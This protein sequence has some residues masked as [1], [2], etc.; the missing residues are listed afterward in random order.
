MFTWGEYLLSTDGKRKKVSSVQE[1]DDESK[2]LARGSAVSDSVDAAPNKYGT[3]TE[4]RDDDNKGDVSPL[5]REPALEQTEIRRVVSRMA[6][7]TQALLGEEALA[8]VRL[9]GSSF[10]SDNEDLFGEGY[11]DQMRQHVSAAAKGSDTISDDNSDDFTPISLN[12]FS[13]ALAL[14]R[15]IFSSPPLIAAFLGLVVG[16]IPALRDL[17]VGPE[18]PLRSLTGALALCGKM[19]VPAS[20]IML[21]G[22]GAI[23]IEK[24]DSNERSQAFVFSNGARAT[25]LFARAT[26]LGF[27]G[28]LWY[29]ICVHFG[30]HGEHGLVPFLLLLEATVPSAQNV[31][32]LML[33]HGDRKQGMAMAVTILESYVVAVPFMMLYLV[34]FMVITKPFV[35]FLEEKH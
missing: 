1:S 16:I 8:P 10:S 18:A 30:L 12:R 24:R 2:P 26:C 23:N 19:Q 11:K 27:C 14:L 5:R 34:Y 3:L 21:S 35:L 31:V 15:R 7:D 32:M 17:L 22:A 29:R 6:L 33:V 9:R 28:Y 13:Q 4:N 25:I 20:M